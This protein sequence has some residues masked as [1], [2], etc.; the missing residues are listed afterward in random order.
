MKVIDIHTHGIGGYDTRTSDPAHIVSMAEIHN[1]HGVSE[2]LPTIYSGPVEEMRASMTAVKAAMELQRRGALIGG[3]YLEGPFLNPA[4]CGALDPGS[5][6]PATENNFRR[7]V[8]GLEDVVRVI[9]VAPEME[10]ATDLIRL[11]ADR[12]IIVTM[13]HS[14]ATFSEADGAFQAGA[15]GMTHIFNGMRGFHHREP[16]IAA[17]GLLNPHLYVE[18][19]GDPYHLHPSVLDLLFRVKNPRR[20]I[21][22]SDS[23]KDTGRPSV[24][25]EPNKRQGILS[26]G[27]MSVTESARRLIGAGFSEEVVMASISSNPFRYLGR[28]G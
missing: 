18:V 19:I 20:I 26:G 1:S 2:F 9:A 8:E 21:L 12:G 24:D 15:T 22:V 25:P 7:L 6:I 11:M 13:G 4:R 3:V 16:G 17:F 14:N 27:S 10:G 28:A 23:V 5:F